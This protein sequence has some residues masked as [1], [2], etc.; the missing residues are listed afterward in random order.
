MARLVRRNALA[1]AGAV[2]A[3][4]WIAVAVLAP[5]V[6]PYSPLQQ[7]LRERLR[8]PDARHLMG[9]D[10][11]GRDIWSRVIYGSRISLPVGLV[12][13]ASSTAIGTV[14]GSVAGYWGG[15]YD[16]VLMR[17]TDLVMA[18][19][20]IILA[21]A[22]AAALGPG[23]QHAAMALVVVA[24]PAYARVMR[25]LVLSVK[26]YEYVVAARA[27]GAGEG[28]ILLRTVLPNCLGPAVV[29]ATLDLGRA[30]LIFS[31]LSFLGLGAVPPA[32][33]WGAM[34]AGG[35]NAFDQ[36][37]VSGFP[38]LAILSVVLAFNFLGDGLRDA[39]DP[40]LRGA[41]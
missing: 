19:P 2:I 8:P 23:I 38:G 41:P 31:G 25:G 36:W 21:M 14:L 30:I 17:L 18:F 11:L 28:R 12:V 7:N 9:T 39:L 35:I 32:P 27:L 26:S 4:G 1:V 40:R 16:A 22:V 29:M 3:A 37:W 33:E 6:A 5:W 13:V 15:L 20:P 34:V 24:W 10:E